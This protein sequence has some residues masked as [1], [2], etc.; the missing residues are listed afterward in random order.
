MLT[1]KVWRTE[2]C[3]MVLCKVGMIRAVWVVQSRDDKSC[4]TMGILMLVTEW[5]MCKDGWQKQCRGGFG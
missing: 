1:S 4:L 2:G 3:C 5:L